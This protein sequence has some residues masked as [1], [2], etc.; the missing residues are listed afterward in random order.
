MKYSIIT[1]NYNNQLGLK[2]T[3]NSVV[4]QT[5][6][7]YEYI[8]ID[9]GSTDGSVNIIRDYEDV[10]DYWVSEK[11]HGIYHAMNKGV[12]KAHGEYCL[13]LNSGDEFYNNTVMQEIYSLK[14]DE[15]IIVGKVVMDNNH[16]IISPP[17]VSGELT[18]YHLYSGAIP[19]Q[20]SFIKTDLLRKY[21]YDESLKISSD[22]RFFV[23]TL[24]LDN[25]SIRYLDIYVSKYNMDGISSTNPE[26]MRHEKD[27]ILSKLFPPRILA[28]YRQMKESECLTQTITPQLRHH[29][30]IDRFLF[31]LGLLIL[32]FVKK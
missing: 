13:F 4:K 10:I 29:Y 5:C 20:G 16:H 31:K 11:D 17:P 8:I 19:H 32:N 14:M 6:D 18:L 9:G 26:L 22:W 21:P 2:Q 27:I 28:D 12:A 30:R 25:C 24:I 3:I 7:D 23:Q 1:I 15:D